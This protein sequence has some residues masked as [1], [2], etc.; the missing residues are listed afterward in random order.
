LQSNNYGVM[1]VKEGWRDPGEYD[2]ALTAFTYYYGVNIPLSSK[3]IVSM[4]GNG[5]TAP[6]Q[7][8]DGNLLSNDNY[9]EYLSKDDCFA[10]YNVALQSHASNVVLVTKQAPNGYAILPEEEGL[11]HGTKLNASV[12]IGS[13]VPVLNATYHWEFPLV[14]QNT[15]GGI[16]MSAHDYL[17][18]TPTLR[19]A[20]TSFDYRYWM[21]LGEV[22]YDF[23]N[24]KINSAVQWNPITWMCNSSA[25]MD[26]GDCAAG[27]SLKVPD[28]WQV[29]PVNYEIDHCYSHPVEEQCT[30]QY[31]F[32]ILLVVISCDVLKL[33]AMISTLIW[34]S[35]KPLAIVGDAIASFMERPDPH[36]SGRCL[37]SQ[38]EARKG[39]GTWPYRRERVDVSDRRSLDGRV[40]PYYEKLG[41]Q[42]MIWRQKVA[43]WY[44]AP[45]KSRWTAFGIL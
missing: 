45:S 23:N 28:A 6:V 4:Y 33:V 39:A 1:I 14:P 27:G 18:Y 15:S 21:M 12:T 41:P 5:S 29:T 7:D 9:F 19:S 24:S 8:F 16:Y 10:R 31:S 42:A 40:V 36:T 44:S 26:E 34:V 3:F 20:F 25:V 11:H 37:L 30:L 2:Q 43:R 38:K 22:G 35:E 17:W 13:V 32:I